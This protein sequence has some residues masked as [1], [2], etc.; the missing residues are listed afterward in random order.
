MG[1]F[2]RL[3]G[4]IHMSTGNVVLSANLYHLCYTTLTHL[5][6]QKKRLRV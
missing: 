4:N 5:S 3:I 1:N 6:F 2:G